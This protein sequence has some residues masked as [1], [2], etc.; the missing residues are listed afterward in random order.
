MARCRNF[1][2]PL[3][4]NLQWGLAEDSG[5]ARKQML[6]LWC[7]PGSPW[8]GI[9]IYFPFETARETFTM[10]AAR[11]ARRFD[12]GG[13]LLW[14]REFQRERADREAWAHDILPQA[15]SHMNFRTSSTSESVRMK[16]LW[17]AACFRHL[18]CWH[19][20]EVTFCFMKYW[21]IPRSEHYAAPSWS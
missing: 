3:P 14:S 12:A 18:P 6:L 15:L 5:V 13:L 17:C 8:G 7:N 10:D 19:V 9:S 11:A 20:F 4:G 21:R 1:Q 2:R 16:L